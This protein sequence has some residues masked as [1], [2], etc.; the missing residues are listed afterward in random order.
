MI[1]SF[2][3]TKGALWP[4]L[5]P[6]IYDTSIEEVEIRYANNSHRKELFEGLKIA[7]RNAANAIGN[8]KDSTPLSDFFKRINN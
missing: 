2:I 3:I 8:L 7:L 5:P 4:L 1:P 6:G